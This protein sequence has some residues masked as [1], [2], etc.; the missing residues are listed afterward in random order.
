[1]TFLPDLPTLAPSSP[2][3]F[4]S[5]CQFHFASVS[6]YSFTLL[7]NRKSLFKCHKR[8]CTS[9]M[10]AQSATE[11]SC[12]FYWIHERYTPLFENLMGDTTYNNSELK[13]NHCFYNQWIIIHFL[14]GIIINGLEYLFCQTYYIKSIKEI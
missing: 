5:L 4:H 7:Y 6:L 9:S 12:R 3:S 8:I 13:V 14:T 2:H 11:L 1:M 10:T